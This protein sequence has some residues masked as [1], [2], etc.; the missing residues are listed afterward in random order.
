MTQGAPVGNKNAARGRDWRDA[1]RKAVIQGK[2]L[3]TLAKKLIQMAEDGD[4]QALKEIGDR[5]DG[6]P[7]ISHE[8]T[9]EDGGAIKVESTVTFV[10]PTSDT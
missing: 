5:L 9:G 10:R 1:V 3:D 6:K 4:L 8:V 2:K 7:Q